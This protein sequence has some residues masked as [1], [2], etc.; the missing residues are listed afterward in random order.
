MTPVGEKYYREPS[1]NYARTQRNAHQTCFTLQ[2][3][4]MVRG[5][6]RSRTSCARPKEPEIYGQ[7]ERS[8]RRVTRVIFVQS[9]SLKFLLCS[10][11]HLTKMLQ[12]DDLRIAASSTLLLFCFDHDTCNLSQALLI[13]SQ[14]GSSKKN[15]SEEGGIVRVQV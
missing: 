10:P 6:I 11:P 3:V 5:S 2:V 12:T 15:C 1:T 7:L 4:A 13:F 9:W 14:R 8:F